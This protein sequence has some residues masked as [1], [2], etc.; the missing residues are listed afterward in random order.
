M[1]K[2]EIQLL[3]VPVPQG[4]GS[5]HPS[6]FCTTAPSTCTRCDQAQTPQQRLQEFRAIF[7]DTKTPQESGERQ[8][9]PQ[10]NPQQHFLR[11]VLGRSPAPVWDKAWLP[12]LE[13]HQQHQVTHTRLLHLL[14]PQS[15]P[16]YSTPLVPGNFINPLKSSQNLKGKNAK[17]SLRIKLLM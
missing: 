16:L 9:H 1:P 3:T 5:N 6:R 4:N 14:Q 11:H 10:L 7:K 2:K 13:R 17:I 15:P 8:L 12:S